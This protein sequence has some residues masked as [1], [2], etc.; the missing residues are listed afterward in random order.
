MIWRIETRISQIHI[1]YLNFLSNE[2]LEQ[3]CSRVK[4]LLR[5]REVNNEGPKEKQVKK[6]IQEFNLYAH[7]ISKIKIHPGAN[8][9]V[10]YCTFIIRATKAI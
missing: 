9:I 2:L 8:Q 3:L 4:L 10:L 6:M 5:E 7:W 1:K